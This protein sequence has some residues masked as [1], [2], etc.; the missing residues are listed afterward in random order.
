MRDFAG[1]PLFHRILQ[2]LTD[3]AF[4]DRVILDS[5]SEEILESAQAAFPEIE[6]IVRPEHLR[7]DDVPMNNLILNACETAGLDVVLQTHATSPLLT[8]ESI[9]AAVQ[10]FAAD[11]ST[12]SLFSVTPM[13]TRLYWDDLSP[14]NHDPSEL[15]PTQDLPVVYEENSN[16]YIVETDALRRC[17]H[18][19][20]DAPMTFVMDDPLESIDID[21][22][23]DFEL[24]LAIH[25]FRSGAH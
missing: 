5:D 24:A 2:T 3:A 1:R 8:S 13:Q 10:A 21:N 25:S 9:D 14:I 18:R 20:T 16:I 17:G 4:V 11:Q 7:G 12:T 22:E 23:V 15:L 6:L 19:V